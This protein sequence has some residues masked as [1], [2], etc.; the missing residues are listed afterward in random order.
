MKGNP[1]QRNFGIGKSPAKAAGIFK[2]L[3]DGTEKRISKSEAD[4]IKEKDLDVTVTTTGDDV[5][6]IPHHEADSKQTTEAISKMNKRISKDKAS[7]KP[8]QDLETDKEISREKDR[9]LQAKA[10]LQ[11][12]KKKDSPATSKS[13][14]KGKMWDALKKGEFKKAGRAVKQEAKAVKEYVVN[15]KGRNL[16]SENLNAKRAYRAEKKRQAQA[17]TKRKAA[18]TTAADKSPAK[19]PLLALAGPIMGML[20]GKKE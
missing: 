15:R 10:N 3:P 1:M 8:V 19:C 5:E 20:G 9:K 2:T 6:A 4:M 14:A 11:T 16:S 17:R 18:R 7:N 12:N 13:P